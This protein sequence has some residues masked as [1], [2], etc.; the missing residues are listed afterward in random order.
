LLP[1]QPRYL[2]IRN[3]EVRLTQC[4][5]R[6]AMTT[7]VLCPYRTVASRVLH[8]VLTRIG[9]DM[10]GLLPRER[11]YLRSL[12]EGIS[13]G[14]PL[15]PMHSF[16]DVLIVEFGCPFIKRDLLRRNPAQIPGIVEWEGFLANHTKYDVDLIDRDLKIG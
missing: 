4:L 5:A 13:K 14:T 3:G 1:Y 7:N 12:A 6:S 2:V 8:L 16:W 9:G 11:E 10:T 15:N